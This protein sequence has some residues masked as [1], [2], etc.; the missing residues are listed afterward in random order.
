MIEAGGANGKMFQ[1]MKPWLLDGDDSALKG[2]APDR[3]EGHALL[4]RDGRG[5]AGDGDHRRGVSQLYRLV[6]CRATASAYMPVLP[7]IL[8][9]LVAVDHAEHLRNPAAFGFLW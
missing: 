1:M 9:E 5:G 3:L 4:Q 7:G 2:P 6:T 8:A